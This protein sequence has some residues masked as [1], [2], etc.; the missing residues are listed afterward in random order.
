VDAKT[1]ARLSKIYRSLSADECRQLKALATGDRF[2]PNKAIV[3]KLIKLEL[4]LLDG[5]YLVVTFDGQGVA[6]WC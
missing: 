1:W 3:E 4:V 5:D 6:S 2:N